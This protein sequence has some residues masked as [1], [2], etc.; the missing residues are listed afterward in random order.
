[1]ENDD[2]LSDENLWENNQSPELDN[3]LLRV[4]SIKDQLNVLE[5]QATIEKVNQPK[6]ANNDS[7]LIDD[8]ALNSV[9]LSESLNHSK[10]LKLR[11]DIS[12]VEK[13]KRINEEDSDENILSNA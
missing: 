3:F 12:S 2:Q 7:S 6:S 13:S 11:L 4:N 10:T 5:R 8:S 1:M 9:L